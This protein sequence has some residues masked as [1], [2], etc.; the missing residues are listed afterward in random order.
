M[1]IA[2]GATFA[3]AATALAEVKGSG[4]SFPRLAYQGWCVSSG[5]L[6]SYTSV[7]SGAG[8]KA[9]ADGLVDFAASDAPLTD[10][11][12][13]T[14]SAQRGGSGVLYFPT[15][16]GA[17]SIPVNVPGAPSNIQL[18]G[19]TVGQIF[20]GDITNW[21]DARI[22]ADNALNPRTKGFA[23]PN[24][25][26][27]VCVRSDGSGTSFVASNFFAKASPEFK[28]KV[29]VGQQPNWSA[30][31]IVRSQQSVGVVNCVKSTSGSVGY[32]DLGD[33]RN[34]GL[35]RNVAAIGKSEVIKVPVKV[36]GKTK[37]VAKR[38]LVF[39]VPS[40][41]AI[42]RAGNIDAASIPKNLVVDMSLSPAKS[43]YPIVTTTWVLAYSD[44]TAA[45]KAGSLAGVKSVLDYFYSSAAQAQLAANSFA[46]LP[47]PLLNAA[48]A[49]MKLLK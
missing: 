18:R 20:S 25:P 27:T 36:N 3:T 26:I 47:V 2:A 41:D 28:A 33:A 49:Q 43:A 29:T 48:K 31:Q 14:L 17:V 21:N 5:G 32:V 16:L 38:R 45:G 6:C 12:L 13:A 46:A 8:I 23:F 44:Y 4:A 19:R 39:S 40:V 10:Q 22:K 35:S 34:A 11:Q 15:L 24:L 1:A 30:P 7:G 37:L 9:L 42:Q